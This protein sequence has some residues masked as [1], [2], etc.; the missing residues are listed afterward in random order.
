MNGAVAKEL[1]SMAYEISSNSKLKDETKFMKTI[2]RYFTGKEIE[3]EDGTFEKEVKTV[4]KITQYYTGYRSV[5]QNIKKMWK[6]EGIE[7]VRKDRR[8]FNAYLHLQMRK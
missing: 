8:E 1:R 7:K 6:R 3:K 5:Y 4:D 2:K